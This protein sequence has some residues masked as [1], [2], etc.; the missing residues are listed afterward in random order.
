MK[1]SETTLAGV[2]VIDL[3]PHADER[4]F[5]ARVWELEAFEAHGLTTALSQV[6]IA[7]NDRAGTLRGLHFQRPPYEDAKLV[8]CTRGV[9]FDVAV[10]LRPASPTYLRWFGVELSAANRRALYIAEGFA[11]GYQTLADDT[12][13][14]YLHS[15]PYVPACEG[16]ARFDDPA[17]GIEWPHAD[18]RILSAKDR[19]WPL[20]G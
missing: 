16:G 14:M 17:F 2:V 8:R 7:F 18:P 4:G 11:H 9:L 20:L 10:D 1:F 6:N 13:A 3:E 19:A 12:E 15:A 5:F